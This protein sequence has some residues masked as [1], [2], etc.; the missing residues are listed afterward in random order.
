MRLCWYRLVT[1][2]LIKKAY[3]NASKVEASKHTNASSKEILNSLKD[4]MKAGLL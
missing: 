1:L 2:Q 4:Y 3:D